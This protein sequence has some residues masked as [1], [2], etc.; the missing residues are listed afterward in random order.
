MSGDEEFLA[1]WSRRKRATAEPAD[2]A[3]SAPQAGQRQPDSAAPD[4]NDEKKPEAEFDLASL[5]SIESISSITDVSV[6][7]RAG[8]P[9]ELTRAALRRAWSIDPQV[10]DF[11]G[12]SE[13]SW[14]FTK[15]NEIAGFGPLDATADI[16][17]MLAEIMGEPRQPAEA[18][19]PVQ[20]ATDDRAV[21]ASDSKVVTAPATLDQPV[22][23]A[24]LAQDQAKGSSVS[25]NDSGVSATGGKVDVALQQQEP[26]T[27][28]DKKLSHRTHG[29]ALP[30]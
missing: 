16:R 13:N 19:G 28:D 20:P 12:L 21:S 5:P 3:A 7:L 8:V 27:K 18:A 4:G 1:R 6:F 2:S 10:R 29:R 22:Q 17:R 14:D 15:P 23:T 9:L 26:E 11:I 24:K 30:Q 25:V